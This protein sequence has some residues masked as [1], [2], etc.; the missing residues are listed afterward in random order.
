MIILQNLCKT[1]ELNLETILKLITPDPSDNSQQVPTGEFARFRRSRILSADEEKFLIHDD[2]RNNKRDADEGDLKTFSAVK[3]PDSASND[4]QNH[5]QAV[6]LKKSASQV[7]GSRQNNSIEIRD[8]NAKL[9][10]KPSETSIETEKNS[11]KS[12]MYNVKEYPKQHA[13]IL[14]E[15]NSSLNSTSRTAKEIK[16]AIKKSKLN[17][18]FKVPNEQSGS[19]SG[20]G[21][22]DTSDEISMSGS[23]EEKNKKSMVVS[24]FVFKN[25]TNG[26]ELTLNEA[27]FLSNLAE[28]GSLSGS[29]SGSGDI[30]DM[31]GS[32]AGSADTNLKEI[33]QENDDSTKRSLPTNATPSYIDSQNAGNRA[34][35]TISNESA[36]VIDD[37]EKQI[38]VTQNSKNVSSNLSFKEKPVNDDDLKNN[39]TSKPVI[40]TKIYDVAHFNSMKRLNQSNSSIATLDPV[41]KDL[42]SKPDNNRLKEPQLV[43]FEMPDDETPSSEKKTLLPKSQKNVTNENDDDLPGSRGADFSE[44]DIQKLQGNIES[45]DLDLM[46][47]SNP[48]KKDSLLQPSSAMALSNSTEIANATQSTETNEVEEKPWK[49][50][51][52]DQDLPGSVGE[53]KMSEIT[54]VNEDAKDSSISNNKDVEMKI[55]SSIVSSFD[56]SMKKTAKNDTNNDILPGDYGDET[57]LED[58][59]ISGMFGTES[60]GSETAAS[61]SGS[62]DPSENM[63]HQMLTKV[64][65]KSLNRQPSKISLNKKT[66]VLSSNQTVTVTTQ[67][68]EKIQ[69]LEALKTPVNHTQVS[70]V[71]QQP[72][73][74]KAS[75]SEQS[76][77]SVSGSGLSEEN[78]LL[79]GS[80]GSGENDVAAASK[81]TPTKQEKMDSA[82]PLKTEI[83]KSAD[84]TNIKNVVSPK[85]F[86][87]NLTVPFQSSIHPV[88]GDATYL[89]PEEETSDAESGEI[90]SIDNESGSGSGSGVANAPIAPKKIISKKVPSLSVHDIKPDATLEA[91]YDANHGYSSIKKADTKIKPVSQSDKIAKA[92]QRTQTSEADAS[93]TGKFDEDSVKGIFIY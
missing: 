9:N 53:L 80:S 8:T 39:S 23:G 71:N 50:V 52:N 40:I 75:F 29:G 56:A 84:A 22:D 66:P 72:E 47:N 61:G 74:T 21:E 7:S 41:K 59:D 62:G 51:Y 92:S 24:N 11:R 37:N 25:E 28:T 16:K 4:R 20:S 38:N 89:T 78:E 57:P 33:V 88:E 6:L 44:D 68:L 86:H 58:S 27:A 83:E 3:L 76:G 82:T 13:R 85:M 17:R 31:S 19:G 34:F 43:N 35:K 64:A 73:I 10:I 70:N 54:P 1:E 2:K 87:A 90:P 67:P 48:K 30:D 79:S 65:R 42:I 5:P 36:P 77:D 32:E 60:S 91:E 26:N 14:I 69:P 81:I 55:A 18:R 46:S 93:I 63:V 49:T 45:E 15:P 12:T